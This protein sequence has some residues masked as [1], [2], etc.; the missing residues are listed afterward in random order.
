MALSFV[1]LVLILRNLMKMS[2]EMNLLS[3]ANLADKIVK[4][5]I[6]EFGIL[7]EQKKISKEA[8][9][10]TYLA[11]QIQMNLIETLGFIISSTKALQITK[12]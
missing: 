1:Q 10:E 5:T 11:E 9:F 8:G 7:P 4:L 3:L 2:W 6:L 12:Q